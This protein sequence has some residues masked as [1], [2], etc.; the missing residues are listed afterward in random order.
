MVIN[1]GGKNME[2]CT[3]VG[4]IVIFW[5]LVIVLAVMTGLQLATLQ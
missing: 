3:S 4:D 5:V 2:G 1:Q